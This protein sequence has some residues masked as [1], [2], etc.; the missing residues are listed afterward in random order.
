MAVMPQV[1]VVDDESKIQAF[2]AEALRRKGLTVRTAGTGE[3]AIELL[4]KAPAD[5][6]FLDLR[7]PDMSGLEVLKRVK[8][9]CPEARVV[10]I[11]GMDSADTRSEAEAYGAFG[12]VA[13]P[14]DFT[15]PVWSRLFPELF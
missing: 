14:F 12:Y 7:L 5:V 10:I 15:D 13:K 11:T 3:E 2:L 1:L 4:A 9:I 6:V 8:D